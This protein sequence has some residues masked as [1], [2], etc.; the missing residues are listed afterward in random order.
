MFQA[1]AAINPGTDQHWLHGA[2]NCWDGAATQNYI[3]SWDSSSTGCMFTYC[4]PKYATQVGTNWYWEQQ[5][6]I[7][8]YDDA[9]NH[10]IIKINSNSNTGQISP[11]GYVIGGSRPDLVGSAWWGGDNER[12]YRYKGY[13]CRLVYWQQ[14]MPPV[15]FIYVPSE[16]IRLATSSATVVSDITG[17][18]PTVR[19]FQTINLLGGGSSCTCTGSGVSDPPGCCSWGT[20]ATI[21]AQYNIFGGAIKD[22]GKALIQQLGAIGNSRAKYGTLSSTCKDTGDNGGPTNCASRGMLVDKVMTVYGVPGPFRATDS[23]LTLQQGFD[24]GYPYASLGLAATYVGSQCGAGAATAGV[25]ADTFSWLLSA[26]GLEEPALLVGGAS[27]IAS[28]IGQLCV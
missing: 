28:A 22:W 12:L 14:G 11:A 24:L 8:Y 6:Q 2:V 21:T 15:S 4:G 10:L 27:I 26:M 19:S 16:K 25:T 7:S 9:G 23:I 13:T 17:D 3:M 1:V 18:D 20:E 5:S